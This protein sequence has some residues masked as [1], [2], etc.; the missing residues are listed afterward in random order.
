MKVKAALALLYKILGS[1]NPFDRAESNPFPPISMRRE[2]ESGQGFAAGRGRALRG[3]F[4]GSDGRNADS[5]ESAGCIARSRRGG[6]V[7]SAIASPRAARSR[8][9]LRLPFR[10]H[11]S[12]FRVAKCD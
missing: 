7:D 11:G 2:N 6:G 5:S 3:S 4:A 9:S 1:V 8:G 12:G 10:S